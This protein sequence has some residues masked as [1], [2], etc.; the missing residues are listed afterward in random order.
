ML[1]DGA[2]AA[3]EAR[4]GGEFDWRNGAKVVARAWLNPDYRA[5]LLRDGT[6]A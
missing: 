3:I 1:P 4:A 2:L 6:S 5:R